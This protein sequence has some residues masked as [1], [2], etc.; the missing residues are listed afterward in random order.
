MIKCPQ[1]LPVDIDTIILLMN[2]MRIPTEESPA[3][4]PMMEILRTINS[5]NILEQLLQ[6]M[7][8]TVVVN[9][10]RKPY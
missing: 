10:E 3:F 7:R 9:K 6:C 5:V 2:K 1:L 8:P 4:F